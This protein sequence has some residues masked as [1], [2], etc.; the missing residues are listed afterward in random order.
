MQLAEASVLTGPAVLTRDH[1]REVGMTPT[2]ALTSIRQQ[3]AVAKSIRSGQSRR[4]VSLRRLLVLPIVLLL[5]MAPA[6]PVFAASSA[7]K[8]GLSG[9]HEKKP[10]KKTPVPFK[11][12]EL[13]PP[14]VP[15]GPPAKQSTLPFTGFNL[16]WTVGFGLLMV[17]AGGSI[18]VVQRRQRRSGSR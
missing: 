16:S 9:Y 2:D 11:H 6:A 18:V 17:G 12:K 4:R 3:E 15:A 8:E 7:N 14:E 5:A 1:Q 13:P 10:P